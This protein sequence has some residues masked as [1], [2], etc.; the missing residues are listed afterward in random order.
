[1]LELIALV[2]VGLSGWA[3]GR[4]KPAIQMP[5]L[6]LT[7][8][9]AVSVHSAI[10]WAFIDGPRFDTV[11]GDPRQGASPAAIVPIAGG[12]AI[13]LWLPF[14]ILPWAQ[15]G[16]RGWTAC[17]ALAACVAAASAHYFPLDSNLFNASF[18]APEGPPYLFAVVACLPVALVGYLMSWR[19]RT[20]ADMGD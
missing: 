15:R 4:I 10:Q 18:M 6:A 12:E 20:W 9:A 2:G 16:L 8:F 1:V 7:L 17:Y 14:L 3:M 5:T 19:Q 11:F 13:G